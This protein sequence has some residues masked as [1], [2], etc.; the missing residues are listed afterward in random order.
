MEGGG[1][2]G[3]F[4]DYLGVGTTRERVHGIARLGK[5][6]RGFMSVCMQKLYRG[7]AFRARMEDRA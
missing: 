6:G 2:G 3:Y 5:E 4:V 7:N 1:G